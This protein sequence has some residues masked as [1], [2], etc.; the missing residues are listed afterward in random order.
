MSKHKKHTGIKEAKRADVQIAP[1]QDDG[2][3]HETNHQNVKQVSGAWALVFFA[4]LFLVIILL[5][6]LGRS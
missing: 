6:F 3:T 4:A 5:G 1:P 2:I